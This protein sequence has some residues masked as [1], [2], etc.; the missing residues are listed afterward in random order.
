M[1]QLIKILICFFV[2]FQLQG[3]SSEEHISAKT[4]K[5]SGNIVDIENRATFPGEIVVENGVIAE[6]KR[7]ELYRGRK[8]NQDS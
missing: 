8:A 1:K 6:I 4:Y 3:C 5:L 2:V 7:L